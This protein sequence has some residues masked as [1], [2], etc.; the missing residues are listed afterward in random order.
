MAAIARLHITFGL[1]S[2]PVTVHAACERQ[3]V[4]LHQVHAR[5]GASL[6]SRA[7][8]IAQGACGYSSTAV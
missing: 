1:V 3:A 8:G 5:D 7:V 6:G 2:I 4:P